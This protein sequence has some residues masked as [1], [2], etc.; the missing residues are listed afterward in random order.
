VWLWAHHRRWRCPTL[1]DRLAEQVHLIA[2]DDPG[3]GHGDVVWNRRDQSF[4][5]AEAI[6][7]KT[8]FSES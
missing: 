1:L 4:E 6:A 7:C 3:F 8:D 5:V 2:P